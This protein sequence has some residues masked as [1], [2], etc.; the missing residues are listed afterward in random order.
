[1]AQCRKLE[2]DILAA[3][4]TLGSILYGLF[5]ALSTPGIAFP[6]LV[7]GKAGE[8]LADVRIVAES[9]SP[10]VCRGGTPVTPQAPI[11]RANTADLIC[12]PNIMLPVDQ[13]PHGRFPEE[14]DWLRQRYSEGAVIA[15]VCSGAVLLAETGLLDGSE[16]TTHW[17]YADLFQKYY[18][19]ITFRPERILTISGDDDR[20]VVAG[21]SGSWQDL[22]LYLIA[23][24]LGPEHAVQ[25]AK[26]FLFADHSDGQLPYAALS[27]RI[28]SNDRVIAR[29]QA[30][31][32]ENYAVNQPV[33]LMVESS[34]LPRRTFNR[35]F[36]VATGYRP[37][38]YVHAIRIEEAKQILETTSDPVDAVAR[39]VGYEDTRS[40]RR[41]FLQRAGL[42]PSAYRLRFGQSRFL[43]PR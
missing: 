5:D 15:T 18:P 6:R 29:C 25:T 20:L 34:G 26:V 17:G 38:E 23:R 1:M 3:P 24:F 32:A 13:S 2:I 42:A 39:E 4:E 12:V 10:F 22:A 33:R 40:F 37:M 9:Q 14:V 43:A 7:T 28:Q 11:S 19:A 31:I 36:K 27:R 16:V 41:V 30:W 21:G 8:S 35:R